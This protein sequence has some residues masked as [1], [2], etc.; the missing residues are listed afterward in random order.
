MKNWK[1]PV[2]TRKNEIKPEIE[3]RKETRYGKFKCTTDF[4]RKTD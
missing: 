1:M 2:K 3:N 4:G